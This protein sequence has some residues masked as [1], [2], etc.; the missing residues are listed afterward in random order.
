MVP[1][2]LRSYHVRAEA[3]TLQN[4]D[5]SSLQVRGV[6]GCVGKEGEN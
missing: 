3:G 1:G 4:H 6:E 5:F 2:Q